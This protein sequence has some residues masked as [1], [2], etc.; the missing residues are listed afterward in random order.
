[1]MRENPIGRYVVVTEPVR[2]EALAEGQERFQ[3]FRNVATVLEYDQATDC[4]LIESHERTA[5]GRRFYVRSTGVLFQDEWKTV[6]FSVDEPA[7]H[8]KHI[9]RF[10]FVRT[11]K[12]RTTGFAKVVSVVAPSHVYVQYLFKRGYCAKINYADHSVFVL[13]SEPKEGTKMPARRCYVLPNKQDKRTGF[14]EVIRSKPYSKTANAVLVRFESDRTT[15]EYLD[16]DL[17]FIDG[18]RC[19]VPAQWVDSL[20]GSP[21][22]D[23]RKNRYGTVKDVCGMSKTSLHYV[24]DGD[25]SAYWVHTQLTE[26]IILPRVQYAETKTPGIVFEAKTDNDTFKQFADFATKHK[27]TLRRIGK[28]VPGRFIVGSGTE[29]NGKVSYSIA[30]VP[31]IHDTAEAAETEATRLAAKEKGTRFLVLQVLSESVVI[32]ERIETNEY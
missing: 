13:H 12:E 4:Y 18:F 11:G 20:K 9:G 25:D 2:F 3:S 24:P 29:Q 21:V 7:K 22:Y 5:P 31:H 30:P 32:P 23:T 6:F 8:R 17:L 16:T 15:E 10:V 1:M 27:D 14:A 26:C 28:K 19:F